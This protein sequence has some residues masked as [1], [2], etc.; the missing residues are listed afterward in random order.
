MTLT[1]TEYN[2]IFADKAKRIVGDITWKRTGNRMAS[3][4]RIDIE[5][6]EE[7]PLFLKGWYNPFSGK[8][9]YAIIHR[10]VGRIYG[11]DLGT[12]HI[13]PDGNLVGEKHKNYWLP[14][15]R[16]KWAFVPEDITEPWDRPA[17][18]WVQFCAEANLEHS[19][20]MHPPDVQ[21]VMP[22]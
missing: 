7:Y 6:N 2:A 21:R 19:G 5:S 4:F 11:L 22:L 13:N 3:E 14:G 15:S 18:V 8:L 20:K 10:I 9:S 1:Q 17:E 16:D 12:E